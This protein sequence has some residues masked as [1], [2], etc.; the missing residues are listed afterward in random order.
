MESASETVVMEVF[1]LE[2]PEPTCHVMEVGRGCSLAIS[3]GSLMTNK[4]SA[5]IFPVVGRVQVAG[6]ATTGLLIRESWV[7]IPPGPP[8][9][10]FRYKFRPSG[11]IFSSPTSNLSPGLGLF[12][13]WVLKRV[14]RS[15]LD[16]W[17]IPSHRKEAL[18]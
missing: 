9:L 11:R 12:C 14:R 2:L 17:A 18:A 6:S 5:L 1:G 10:D 15:H 8:E 7:R 16:R 3:H 13:G 4:I